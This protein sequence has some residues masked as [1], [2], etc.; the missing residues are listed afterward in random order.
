MKRGLGGLVMEVDLH[1]VLTLIGGAGGLGGLAALMNALVS[2]KQKRVNALAQTIE[3]MVETVAS[4]QGE[5]IR[6]KERKDE[7]IARCE[8]LDELTQALDSENG[9]LQSNNA[10]LKK[11][12]EDCNRRV[13]RLENAPCL[14]DNDV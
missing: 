7:C 12:L 10:T 2:Q 8:A 5:N 4:L 6:L 3:V 13:A 11:G 1:N 14:H 9:R